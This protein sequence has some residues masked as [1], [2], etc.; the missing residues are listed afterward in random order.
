MPFGAVLCADGGVAFRL[1][2]PGARRVDVRLAGS[3]ARPIPMT[4]PDAGWYAARSDSAG[5][6]A[7]YQFI[8]DGELRGARPG[9]ALPAA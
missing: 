9:V 3:A 4:G 1:W 7:L 2:A 8:I 5:A 6:G